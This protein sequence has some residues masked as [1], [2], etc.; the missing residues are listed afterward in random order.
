MQEDSF[1]YG[2]PIEDFA[3]CAE[4]GRNHKDNPTTPHLSK[5]CQILCHP[6]AE[7]E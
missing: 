5:A 4:G 3:E 2:S 7:E 6:G 1:W